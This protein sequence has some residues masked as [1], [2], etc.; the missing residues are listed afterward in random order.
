MHTK[1]LVTTT[2][3]TSLLHIDTE[4][5]RLPADRYCEVE[6]GHSERPVVVG[7]K[8]CYDGWSGSRVTCF[9]DTNQR[10]RQQKNHV[11]LR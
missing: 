2:K 4:T 7:K 6:C 3:S 5:N 1:L 10:S 11:I 9:A 8:I